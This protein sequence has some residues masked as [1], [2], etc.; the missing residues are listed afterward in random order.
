MA[1]RNLL[2]SPLYNVLNYIYWFLM[3]NIFFFI[4]NIPLIFVSLARVSS[5]D[6]GIVIIIFVSFIPLGPAITALFSVMGKLVRTK[7][8]FI[9][10]DYFGAYKKNFKQ[11]L[12]VWVID[13][14]LIAVFLVD[15][16]Y[17]SKTPYSFI[18][19]F[20]M[21][22]IVLVLASSLYAFP[23]ISRFYM[24]TKDV[25]VLSLYFTI[26]K[27]H[28]TIFNVAIIIISFFII[29]KVSSVFILFFVSVI[30]FLIMFYNKGILKEI[31]L[32]TVGETSADSEA[33]NPDVWHV[34]DDETVEN[35][36]E[37]EPEK[38]ENN[39]ENKDEQ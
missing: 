30:C 21:V 32:K 14:A 34:P 11:S 2:D 39:D 31:E 19:P 23:I 13:L 15:I 8:L 22:L 9:M 36:T 37:A 12:L 29:Y 7:D 26:K 33:E 16:K 1:S 28:I 20:F 38:N 24:R 18:V 5:V 4:M 17:F 35:K 25:F 3:G 27:I 6:L 10:K